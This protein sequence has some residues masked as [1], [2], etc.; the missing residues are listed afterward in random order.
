MVGALI[1]YDRCPCTKRER[2]IERHTGRRHLVKTE[3]GIG[4]MALKPTDPKDPGRE[5][6]KDSPSQPQRE[7]ALPGPPP[8]HG[9][10]SSVPVWVTM[11]LEGQKFWGGDEAAASIPAPP[12][13]HR[14]SHGVGAAPHPAPL[15]VPTSVTGT[16]LSCVPPRP[17]LATRWSSPDME[18]TPG[19]WTPQDMSLWGDSGCAYRN[20]G[21]QGPHP[22]NW[23][24]GDTSQGELAPGGHLSASCWATGSPALAALTSCPWQRWASVA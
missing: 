5:V 23:S 17:M 8:G 24:L 9:P 19:H 21:T 3:V 6:W 18:S 13:G 14:E 7:P 11:A 4:A 15:T 20:V 1:Q 22:D 12:G 16:R 10:V 2:D